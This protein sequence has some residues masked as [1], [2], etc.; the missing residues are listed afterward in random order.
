M[1]ISSSDRCADVVFGGAK[2]SYVSLYCS[3]TVG[4]NR[5][6]KHPGIWVSS[7][8]GLSSGLMVNVSLLLAPLCVLVLVDVSAL[9]RCSLLE[10]STKL[11]L[12]TR[13]LA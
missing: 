1:G 5:N 9:R 10:L 13:G 4:G 12:S 11:I 8:C 3:P 7:S 2:K 6:A